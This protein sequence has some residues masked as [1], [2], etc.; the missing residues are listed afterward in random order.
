MELIG[1][2]IPLRRVRT[3]P[4]P[5]QVWTKCCGAHPRWPKPNAG[6]ARPRTSGRSGSWGW[7]RPSTVP[8]GS[9]GS[10]GSEKL[11]RSSNIDL[12]HQ[13]SQDDAGFTMEILDLRYQNG[14]LTKEMLDLHHRW[15]NELRVH[16][17]KI[18]N[19]KLGWK[20][21]DRFTPPFVGL[22][23]QVALGSR[24]RTASAGQCFWCSTLLSEQSHP[25]PLLL[26]MDDPPHHQFFGCLI[27]W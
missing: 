11:R 4:P 17:L 18:M 6:A 9:C 24:C 19:L 22:T 14:D 27:T 21:T 15:L 5:S 13:K 2:A 7:G 1:T 23:I 20:P 16:H 26:S 12:S 25:S 8:N 3:S 10:G